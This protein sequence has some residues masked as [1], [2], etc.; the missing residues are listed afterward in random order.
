MVTPN[1]GVYVQPFPATGA[2]YQVPKQGIDFHPVWAPDGTALIYVPSAASGQLAVVSVTTRPGVTFGSLVSLP[3]RVTADRLSTEMRAYDILPGDRFV[4]LVNS[5]ESESSRAA[6]V[7]EIRV[8]LNWFEE[9][10]QRL[11]AK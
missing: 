11:P 6:A 2:I 1:R 8:V 5:S 9:L 10:K 4:G 3:A 7:P